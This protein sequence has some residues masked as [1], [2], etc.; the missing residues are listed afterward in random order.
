L[1]LIPLPEVVVVLAIAAVVFGWQTFREVIL[2]RSEDP[3]RQRARLLASC[4][5]ITI[6]SVP[7]I[8]RVVPPNG[9]YGF[10]NAETLS[11]RAIWYQA[12]AFMGWALVIASAISATIVVRVRMTARRSLVW[13]GFLLPLCGA[14]V[15]AFVYLNHLMESRL[16]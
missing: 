7:L 11:N 8:L 10:R 16:L 12:N 2:R 9:V 5:L 13:A 3:Q 15:A 1:T 6:I 4:V 14:I